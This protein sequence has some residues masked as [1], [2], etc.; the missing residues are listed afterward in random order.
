M[1]V[2]ISDDALARALGADELAAAFAG[3]GHEVHRTSSW[4]ML[5]L[6]PLVEIDGMGFGPATTDEVDAIL[7]YVLAD[8]DERKEPRSGG[9]LGRVLSAVHASDER[10]HL[11]RAG[12]SDIE[13]HL[14]RELARP[15]RPATLLAHMLRLE[16]DVRGNERPRVQ[17]P[18]ERF[19]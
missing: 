13:R 12:E 2:R 4:G 17:H 5:W 19:S 9:L 3:K 16:R 15:D 14:R 1:I 6:E 7:E 11:G 8:P 10:D 18:L